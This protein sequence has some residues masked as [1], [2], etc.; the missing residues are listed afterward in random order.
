MNHNAVKFLKLIAL[1]GNI[2]FILWVS[3]NAIDEGFG[4][5]GPEKASYV[6]L[7]ILLILNSWLILRKK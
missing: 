5:T 4:G 1:F 6:G 7:M 2:L 3:Y